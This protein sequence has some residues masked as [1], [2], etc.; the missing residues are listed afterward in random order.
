MAGVE[1][2]RAEPR[3]AA[4]IARI[5]HERSGG[6]IEAIEGRIAGEIETAGTEEHLLL[7]A[8][9]DM[10]LA[11]FGRASYFLPL[12]EHPPNVAPRGWYLAGLIVA[13]SFRRHGIGHALTSRRL[14]HLGTSAVEAF[15]FASALNRASIDLHARFGFR[16]LTRDFFFPGVSFTGGTGVLYRIELPAISH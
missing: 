16:E 4:E 2:R 6:D 15:Y 3:D 5:T 12:P 13:V 8:V 14:E 7:V 9:V 11:G 10:V 1:I